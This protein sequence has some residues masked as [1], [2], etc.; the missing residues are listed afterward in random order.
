MQKMDLEM[1][2]ALLEAG[3]EMDEATAQD[4]F[5]AAVQLTESAG[6]EGPL[7]VEVPRLLHHV[8]DADFQQWE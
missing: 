2:S 3:A 6:E 1:A 5:W 4:A 8:F 7:P